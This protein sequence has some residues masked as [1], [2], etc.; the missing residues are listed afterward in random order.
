MN[1]QSLKNINENLRSL[2]GIIEVWIKIL[3]RLEDGYKN[4]RLFFCI[5]FIAQI[6]V[7]LYWI[8]K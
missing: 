6:I 4:F 7:N 5:V 2:E 8:T 1:E 3:C